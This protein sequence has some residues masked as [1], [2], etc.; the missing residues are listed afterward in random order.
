[1]T[2]VSAETS[3]LFPASVGWDKQ[4]I[5][6]GVPGDDSLSSLQNN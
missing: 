6:V 2:C 1:M 5:V 4:P 3:V